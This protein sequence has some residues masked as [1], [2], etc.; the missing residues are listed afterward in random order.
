MASLEVIA[1]VF[2]GLSITAS[3]IYYASVLSNANKT[4]RQA[5]ETRQAQL[6][7][8]LYSFYDNKEFLKDY[9]NIT[10]VYEYGGVED[11]WEKY[12]PAVDNEAYSSWLRVGRFFDGVG[13]LMR[14]E[15]IEKELIF[16]LLGDVIKGS[17]EGTSPETG[18]ESFIMGGREYWDM[19]KLWNNFEYLY[20]ELNKYTAEHTEIET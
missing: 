15:L 20:K 2:T 3:I 18:M 17:W 9:G 12:S 13:I 16:D 8:Q 5:H 11:W 4:Q 6:Y 10:N 1:L 7:M 14:R 19:P